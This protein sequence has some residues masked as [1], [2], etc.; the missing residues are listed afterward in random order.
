MIRT[1]AG[2]PGQF[3]AWPMKLVMQFHAARHI[4]EDARAAAVLFG[5]TTSRC[6]DCNSPLTNQKSREAGIGPK[7]AKKFR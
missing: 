4:A 3:Q 2:A 1:L 7:C 6:F 5:R